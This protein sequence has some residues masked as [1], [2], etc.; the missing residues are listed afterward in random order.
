M[1]QP[2]PISDPNN[3]EESQDQPSVP[4]K[5]EILADLDAYQERIE[6]QWESAKN[7]YQDKINKILDEF[8]Q[9]NLH[10]PPPEHPS[11]NPSGT[12]LPRVS[13][14]QSEARLEQLLKRAEH[15]INLANK[16]SR[17]YS[18]RLEPSPFQL[19]WNPSRSLWSRIFIGHKKII[20][21]LTL[22]LI[23][24]GGW[25]ITYRSVRIIP[26]PYT[27][28]TGLVIENEKVFVID[29]FRRTL[30]THK[31]SRGF[32][33][34]AVENIPNQF[35]T[36]FAKS[37]EKMWTIDGVSAEIIEHSLSSDHF[38]LSKVASPGK[39]PVGLY[40]DGVDLWSMDEGT[41]ILYRH[42]SKDLEE[43]KS[44]YRL[45][46]ISVS[47]M[48]VIKNRLWVLSEKSR[49]LFEFRLEDPVRELREIDLDPY[50]KGS[51]VT[52]FAMDEKT[53]T[54]TTE[55]PTT[56]VR[57]PLTALNP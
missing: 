1:A 41:K 19:G 15:V 47:A 31:K 35:V 29:W 39:K 30:Y 55:N 16:N 54:L 32:P 18:P 51:S 57:I 42:H 21:G 11:K 10:N 37:T 23:V 28:A 46:N 20:L 26:L 56:L 49:M 52:S 6:N 27:H 44:T 53:L 48:S 2:D 33:I 9:Q 36:G 4:P 22:C 8:I 45:P 34:L 13:P 17:G 38:S 5:I 14:A 24:L 7:L 25:A 3:S 43:I 12:A 50:L 40:F